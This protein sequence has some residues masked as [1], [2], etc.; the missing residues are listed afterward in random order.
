MTDILWSNDDVIFKDWDVV[1]KSHET[2]LQATF[3][4]SSDAVGF[5]IVIFIPVVDFYESLVNQITSYFQDIADANNLVVRYDDDLRVAP[6]EDL[7]CEFNI[8]FGEAEQS[9]IGIDSFRNV[10]NFNIRIKNSIGLGTGE[11]LEKADLIANSFKSIDVNRIIFR[12]PRI[13]NVGR[14]RDDFQVNVI[15]PFFIDN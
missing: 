5:L 9:E 14:I 12:V 10:G 1:W 3:S 2:N 8:D 6:T 4:S 11:L 15:C 13:R 7:W